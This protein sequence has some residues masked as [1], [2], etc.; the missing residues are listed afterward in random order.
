MSIHILF[1]N[2]PRGLEPEEIDQLLTSVAACSPVVLTSVPN[3]QCLKGKCSV[4]S[5]IDALTVVTFT[6]LRA[7]FLL[8]AHVAPE[9]LRLVPASRAV[10]DQAHR[11]QELLSRTDR[12][13]TLS[14]FLQE[15]EVRFCFDHRFMHSSPWAKRI[16][17]GR[18]AA[19]DN[20]MSVRRQDWSGALRL[21]NACDSAWVSDWLDRLEPVEENEA[22]PQR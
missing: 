21:C 3:A 13:L 15:C 4:F 19:C 12:W 16:D 10:I 11:T 14:K 6:H 5:W 20:K 7:P 18:R 17:E 8:H 9:S 2:I 1:E 22:T